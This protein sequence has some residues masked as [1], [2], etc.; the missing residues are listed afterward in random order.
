MSRV[1]GARPTLSGRRYSA[2]LEASRAEE[3]ERVRAMSARERMGLA[4]ALG[5]RRLALAQRR[6]AAAHGDA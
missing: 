3:L 6:E 5:R 1:P 4:L 2:C